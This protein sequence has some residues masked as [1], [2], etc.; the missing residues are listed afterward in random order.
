MAKIAEKE[1]QLK[2]AK[3]AYD[4]ETD[5]VAMQQQLGDIARYESEIAALKSQDERDGVLDDEQSLIVYIEGQPVDFREIISDEEEYQTAIIAISKKLDE[6]RSAREQREVAHQEEIRQ[7]KNQIIAL[8]T[9]YNLEIEDLKA[10]NA[11]AADEIADLKRQNEALKAQSPEPILTNRDNNLAERMAALRAKKPAIYNKRQ[12]DLKGT[13]YIA[14]L[15]ETGEEIEIK[16]LEIRQYREASEEEVQRF[17]EEQAQREA[18]MAAI[19]SAE[20]ATQVAT[21]EPPQLPESQ[22]QNSEDAG[23]SEHTTDGTMDDQ[24]DIPQQSWESWVEMAITELHR[25]VGAFEQ[26]RGYGSTFGPP[27]V[28]GDAA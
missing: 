6:L 27:P 4:Q 19:Q 10:K 1:Q 12:G 3:E 5:P 14:T 21:V 26:E 20:E 16:H 23:V 9:D 13:Y 7:F 18:E 2:H 17:R 28:R 25:R 24:S 8:T 11:A 15:L 22:F